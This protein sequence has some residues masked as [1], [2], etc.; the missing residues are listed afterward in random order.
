MKQEKTNRQIPNFMLYIQVPSETARNRHLS[1]FIKIHP[2]TLIK[3]FVDAIES[4]QNKLE[5]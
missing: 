2:R 5:L 1:L 4:L 3:E